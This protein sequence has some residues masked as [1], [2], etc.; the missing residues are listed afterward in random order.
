MPVDSQIVDQF[1]SLGESILRANEAYHQRNEPTMADSE[2]DALMVEYKLL[3]EKFPELRDIDVLESTVGFTPEGSPLVK[4]QHPVRMLSLDNAFSDDDILEFLLKTRKALGLLSQDAMSIYVDP[5]I[6]G[7]ACSLRYENGILVQAATRGDGWTG[8]DITANV[9]GISDIPKILKGQYP[10]VIEVRGE[11]YMEKKQFEELNVQRVISGEKPF[12]TARNA[13]AGSLRQKDP[14]I[15]AERGLRFLAY[16]WGFWD[17]DN[18]RTHEWGMHLIESH[19]FRVSS[20]SK[21]C[22]SNREVIDHCLLI[23]K[24]RPEFLYEIDGAVLKINILDQRKALGTG[25]KFPKWAIAR[26]FSASQGVTKLL[27][28][29][30]QVGRTGKLTPV[31]RLEPVV[32]GGVTVSNATLHNFD[33]VRRLNLVPGDLVVVE[34]AGDVIPKV[35]KNNTARLST[36]PW[37][38]PIVC[39]VCH[40]KARREDGEVDIRCTG[41]FYCEAQ[42]LESLNHFVSRDALNID[43]LGPK[44]IELFHAKGLVSDPASIF[45]LPDWR[46]SILRLDGWSEKS[47]DGLLQAI[48]NAKTPESYKLLYGLGIRH[49]GLSTSRDL[50]KAYGDLPTLRSVIEELSAE[51]G[52]VL[53]TFKGK[54]E[55]LGPFSLKLHNAL[56]KRLGVKGIGPEVVISL[57]TWFLKA[58]NQHLWDILM[59]YT[60]PKPYRAEFLSGSMVAGKTVV[61]T[62]KFDVMSRT[63][64][65]N[66]ARASGAIVTNTVSSKTDLLIAGRDSGSKLAVARKLGIEIVG[67]DTWKTYVGIE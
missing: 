59:H 19:G 4:V 64:I 32:I 25:S 42:V 55:E 7:L 36:A 66:H 23:E 56:A 39:P 46:A 16:G 41:G 60:K 21:S 65:E 58:D 62:G 61:F 48:E 12:A 27:D 52:D 44:T 10:S 51:R 43:G 26:K 30:I 53:F 18:V 31:A 37:V 1:K 15:T 63:E 47:T 11:V 45:A 57:I 17:F 67:E 54:E 9:A 6:D 14:A 24:E 20:Y 22:S 28:I 38:D 34:R 29:E 5:K 13:A 50:L 40:S 3:L 8:E 49:V 33:E 35:I 2:F